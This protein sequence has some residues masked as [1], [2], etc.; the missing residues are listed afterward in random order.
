MDAG[1]IDAPSLPLTTAGS[2]R[3][4][5]ALAF[6]AAI[7]ISSLSRSDDATAGRKCKPKCAECERC[8][9]GKCKDGKCKRSKCKPKLDGTSCSGGRC[10]SGECITATEPP[11]PGCGTGAACLVFVTFTTHQGNLGGLAGADLI[12]QQRAL[13]RGLPGTYK[14]WLS[15]S[16]GSPDSRFMKSTGPYRRLDGVTVADN[17]TDLTTCDL[18]DPFACIDNPIDLMD[19]GVTRTSTA[20]IWTNTGIGGTEEI[21][22]RSCDNWTKTDSDL[23]ANIGISDPDPNTTDKTWTDQGSQQQCDFSF[24]HLYCFQQS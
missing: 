7:G 9:K 11:Q 19:D 20:Q 22:A 10:Q 3:R 8:K 13:T 17:Y 16:T 6:S 1:R 18:S 12:C 21:P 2:R 14:A 23:I 5:L 4:T 15:D 24:T